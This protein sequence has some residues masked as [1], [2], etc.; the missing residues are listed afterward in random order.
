MASERTKPPYN[1]K[2]IVPAGH[3]WASLLRKEGDAL[4]TQYRHILEKLGTQ[5]GMLAEVFKKAKPENAS[6]HG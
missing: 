4:E 1:R 6:P 3:Y 5:A 2:P